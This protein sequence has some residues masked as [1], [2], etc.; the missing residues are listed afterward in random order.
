MVIKI[1]IQLLTSWLLTRKRQK[2][3]WFL[4]KTPLDWIGMVNYHEITLVHKS[5]VTAI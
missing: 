2:V 4:V 3:S 5:Q 1:L